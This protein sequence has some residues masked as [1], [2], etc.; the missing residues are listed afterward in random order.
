MPHADFL[1]PESLLGQLLAQRYSIQALCDETRDTVTYR[2]HHL[3]LDRPVL[4]RVLRG[5]AGVEREAC[6][7]ALLRAR[8]I[9][10]IPL[11]HASR[12]LDVGLLGDG[13]PFIV[14]EYAKGSSL[15]NVLAASGPLNVRRVLQLGLQVA[16]GLS[17]LH[18]AGH[19]HGRLDGDS[20]WLASRAPEP[21]LWRVMGFGV[22]E[23]PR[24]SFDGVTSGVF[25]AATPTHPLHASALVRADIRALGACLYR[26]G[27]GAEPP[28]LGSAEAAILESDFSC[29]QSPVDRALRRGLAMILQRCSYRLPDTSYSTMAELHADLS[30]LELTAASLSPSR[31]SQAPVRAIH[32]PAPRAR[33]VVRHEPK[34]IVRG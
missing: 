14:T 31:E 19:E 2:A 18:A 26:A 27:T 22:I 29:A 33:G 34:V 24:S 4:V 10:A 12:T 28:W 8:Q 16:R 5:R 9:A 13:Q 1:P 17:E 6:R 11:P 20:L 30:R 32:R 3:A 15:P 25:Q 23:L 21:D 7:R